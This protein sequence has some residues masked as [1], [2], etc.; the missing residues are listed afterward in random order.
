V[1]P[2]AWMVL[3]AFGVR[4]GVMAAFH[5]YHVPPTWDRFAFGG[6]MGRIARS[7]VLG[8]GFSSP[9][10]GSTGPTA[11][12]GPVYP[13]VVAG[14]FKLFGI[15]TDA[16]SVALLTFNSLLSAL[17]CIVIFFLGRNTFGS[18]VGS[19]AGWTWTLFPYAVYWPIRWVWDTSLSTLLLTILVWLSF[20]LAD[21]TRRARWVAFGVLAGIAALVNTTLL[22][23]MPVLAA[24]ACWQHRL[25][26][27]HWPRLAVAAA[28]AL[29]L[30]VAPWIVRNYLAFGH[31]LLRSNLGL[32]LS[33]GNYEG[34]AGLRAWHSHPAFDDKEMDKYRRMGELAY[35]A[36]KQH[37][38]LRFIAT[39]PS[40]F[41][42][43]CL[44]R[45][46]YFWTGTA[47]IVIP[48]W[49]LATLAFYVLVSALG[50]AGLV[51]ALRRRTPAA[52][53][54]A[55]VLLVFPIPYYL[56]H[57]E[58]RFRHLIEPELV[59]LGVYAVSGMMARL[60]RLGR[61][62]TQALP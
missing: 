7:I 4:L 60:G 41:A 40:T 39:H 36:E 35:M 32:E 23:L 61:T 62:S 48:R 33:Q 45:I 28:L 26:G 2:I 20:H 24:W 14:A 53:L 6:E 21:S 25:R 58:P 1:P 3:V 50:V 9:L 59:V 30:T 17:T 51:R 34:A 57:P 44:R 10:H 15:Y 46:V 19:W 52:P 29:S 55:L 56:T 42:V 47:E 22:S 38:A 43:L 54:F 11:M 16:A 27:T 5:T 13:Y 12:V 18:A 37:E 8:E 31:I 49:L